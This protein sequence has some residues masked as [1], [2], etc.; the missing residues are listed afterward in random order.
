MR[1][2][3]LQ[4]CLRGQRESQKRTKYIK[5]TKQ[6]KRTINLLPYRLEQFKKRELFR[7]R[8]KANRKNAESFTK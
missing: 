4:K 6:I 8:T 5:K 7:K 1:K 2:T 3:E